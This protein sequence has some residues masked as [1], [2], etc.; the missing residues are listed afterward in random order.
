MRGW[1][2]GVVVLGILAI[3]ILAS[4]NYWV[5]D[6]NLTKIATKLL[7]SHLAET[8]RFTPEGQGETLDGGTTKATEVKPIRFAVL[9]DIHSDTENLKKALEKTN[10][11]N[12]D[13]SIVTGDL[14]TVGKLSELQEVRGVLDKGTRKYYVIPGNHDIYMGNKI[15][16]NLFEQVFGKSYQAFYVSDGEVITENTETKMRAQSGIYKFILIDN[17]DSNGDLR[18]RLPYGEAV[19][20][21]GTP[22]IPDTVHQTPDA[23]VSQWEWIE[24]E[25]EECPKMIC[26]V[27]M[28]MPLNHPTSEHIMGEDNVQAMKQAAELVKLLVKNQVKQVFAGHLHYASSYEID[29]L[30]TQIV[31]A[32]ASERN[33]QSPRYLE[34]EVYRDRIAVDEVTVDSD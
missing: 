8:L 17:A 13:F 2:K 5:G 20:L 33:W 32:V 1:K 14:T 34:V 12:I 29:G 15:G 11:D 24:G 9:S 10:N 18:R 22:G 27:F 30:K 25:T 26:L 3:V 31:G 21:V 23:N 19:A 7:R 4:K 16:Q 28:H 6:F